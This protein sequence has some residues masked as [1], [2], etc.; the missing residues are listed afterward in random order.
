MTFAPFHLQQYRKYEA[1]CNVIF[2][3]YETVF[4]FFLLH[5]ITTYLSIFSITDPAEALRHFSHSLY[6]IA[7]RHAPTEII[8]VIIP[9]SAHNFPIL[10]RAEIKPGPGLDPVALSAFDNSANHSISSSRSHLPPQIKQSSSHICPWSKLSTI[11]SCLLVFYI[12]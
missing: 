8:T 9:G 7:V 5:L 11:T 10:S 6:V 3:I 4:F 12:L 1:K 2:D